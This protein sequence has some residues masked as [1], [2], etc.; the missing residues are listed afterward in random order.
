MDQQN[1]DLM[2]ITCMYRS[3]DWAVYE[4]LFPIHDHPLLYS[5]TNINRGI[6]VT[7]GPGILAIKGASPGL[8]MKQNKHILKVQT[9]FSYLPSQ[10]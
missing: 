4:L 1:Q 5:S 7:R 8:T 10:A 2:F 3:D 9:K 6:L